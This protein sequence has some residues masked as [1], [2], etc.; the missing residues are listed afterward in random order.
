MTRQRVGLDELLVRYDAAHAT[1]QADLAALKKATRELHEA[2]Q[3]T[4][5]LLK[6]CT[7]AD[8]AFSQSIMDYGD[9]TIERW[10]A[11]IDGAFNKHLAA[12]AS[13]LPPALAELKAETVARVQKLVD[14]AAVDMLELADRARESY[15]ELQVALRTLEQSAKR[16][17]LPLDFKIVDRDH[18]DG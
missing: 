12:A 1:A 18:P 17:I 16:G 8:K 11:T 4:K 13:S 9:A 3:A 15:L 14:D 7:E 5:A 6:E 10:R 2:Q